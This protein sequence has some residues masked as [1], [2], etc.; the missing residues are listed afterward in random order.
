[1]YAIRLVKLSFLRSFILYLFGVY[2]NMYRPFFVVE[3]ISCDMTWLSA[4][5]C[6][7]APH[8]H[9]PVVTPHSQCHSSPRNIHIL[10]M[11]AAR[12]SKLRDINDEIER[13]DKTC[14]KHRKKF[15]KSRDR[16]RRFLDEKA[17]LMQ[18]LE[19]S[20]FCMNDSSSYNTPS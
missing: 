13:E 7:S 12:K 15:M 3:S 6:F 16:Y 1:M 10:R 17:P 9:F 5:D 8:I 2:K 19:L 4:F 11:M 20:K 14:N 18:N